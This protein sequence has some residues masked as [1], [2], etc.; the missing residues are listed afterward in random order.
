[1]P[2]LSLLTYNHVR[3]DLIKALRRRGRDIER[4]V[5]HFGQENEDALTE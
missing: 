5:D 4:A 2:G 1:M 3:G